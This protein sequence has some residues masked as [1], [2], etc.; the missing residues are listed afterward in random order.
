[1]SERLCSEEAVQA[2]LREMLDACRDHPL[3]Q[4]STVEIAERLKAAREKH[5]NA[6]GAA[7]AEFEVPKREPKK[8]DRERWLQL[9]DEAKDAS[10][11]VTLL[12]LRLCELGPEDH[13]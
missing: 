13:R 7:R 4:G 6:E 3:M 8:F 11:V 9:M 2:R 5:R 12:G 1:M 10:M